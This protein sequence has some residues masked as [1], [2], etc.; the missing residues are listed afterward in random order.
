[1][2]TETHMYMLTGEGTELYFKKNHAR[3]WAQIP[4]DA[5]VIVAHVQRMSSIFRSPKIWKLHGQ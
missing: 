5:L 4:I 3:H 2:N 1:M